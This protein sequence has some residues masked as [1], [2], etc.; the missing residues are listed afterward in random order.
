MGSSRLPL[1]SFERFLFRIALLLGATLLV[2]R[3]GAMMLVSYLH[4]IR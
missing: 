4:H 2:C 1:N 3:V